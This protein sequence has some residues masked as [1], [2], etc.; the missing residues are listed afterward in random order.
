MY[1]HEEF[2]NRQV[3]LI[4]K[5]R[6]L[7]GTLVE[8]IGKGHNSHCLLATPEGIVEIPD[9]EIMCTILVREYP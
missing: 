7:K 9:N 8:H 6:D 1:V 4:T 3:I 2:L 5:T